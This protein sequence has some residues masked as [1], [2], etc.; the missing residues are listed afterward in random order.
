MYWHS[1]RSPA[2]GQGISFWALGE[3]VRERC[4]LRESDD[5]ATTRERV[6]ATVADFVRDLEERAWIE[7]SL[8][9]LLGFDSGMAADQLFGAWRTFFERISEQGTVV[10]AFED[11]H[12][13]DTGLL[14]FVDHMLD[15]S[16]GLPIFVVTLARPDLIDRRPNWGA[17]KTRFRVDLLE[18]L[19][20]NRHARALGWPRPGLA[21]S[22]RRRHR[23]TGRRRTAVCRRDRSSLLAEGRLI[24]QDGVYVPKGDLSTLTVPAT[25]T[26]LIASRLD[27]LEEIDRRIVR[28]AAVLGQSFTV[29]ALSAVTDVSSSDLEPH[30]AGLVRRELLRREMDAR[31]PEAGQYAFVQGLIREVAYNTLSKPDRKKLH[32][33][34]AR[35]FEALGSEEMA[36]ALATH[37]LAAHENA[38][39][40]PE[41]DALASQARV[42]LK[43]AASRA[44]A[45]GSFA[46]SIEFLEQ[47]LS[48]TNDPKEKCELLNRAGDSAWVLGDFAKAEVFFQQAAD[49]AR[50]LGDRNGTAFSVGRLGYVLLD[51]YKAP[52]AAAILEPAIVEFADIDEDAFLELAAI[53]AR[54]RTAMGDSEGGLALLEPALTTA[55]RHGLDRVLANALFAKSNALYREG[56]RRESLAITELARQVAAETGQTDLEIRATGNLATRRSELDWKAALDAYDDQLELARRTGRREALLGVVGNYGYATFL[57]GEW[58]SGLELLAQTLMEEMAAR[59]RL[60]IQNNELIMRASRGED[61]SAGLAEMTETTRDLS[62]QDRDAAI[63]DVAANFAMA[64]GDLLKARDQFLVV[65]DE[66]SYAPEYVYRAAH[67]VL[68]LSDLKGASDLLVRLEANAGSGPSAAARLAAVRAGVAALEGRT[69]D[70][71]ALY[72]DALRGWRETHG[73]WDQALTGLDMAELLDT[74]DPEVGGRYR[75]DPSDLRAPRCEA[76]SRAPRRR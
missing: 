9:T 15:W 4:Q 50:Q 22:G 52:E 56:R 51:A 62:G 69:A 53:A 58:D 38:T 12:F 72:A 3:I 20:G 54:V 11:M 49:D 24:E 13:A 44:T 34:A 40:G 6:R 2:Y 60:L 19:W 30:L 37:Y 23:R 17:G 74:T 75:V 73:V 65:G 31:S 35:Y 45:L 32:L 7:R 39:E 21:C 70:A 68:W 43:A 63:S 16:R 26:A 5:E 14:D 67:P 46:Q 42:A 1:G 48:V 47:A 59:D 64:S 18:P 10:L 55:E 41:A 33:A 28:D 25:L 27:A 8:L 71:K 66:P 36:G 29:A 76:V 61:V 57:A